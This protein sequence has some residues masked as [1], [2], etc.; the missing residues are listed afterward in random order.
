MLLGLSYILGPLF[1]TWRPEWTKSFVEEFPSDLPE[2]PKL[3]KNAFSRWILT[4]VTLSVIA[5]AA[6][7]VELIP[8]PA[9]LSI[10]SL[11]AGWVRFENST[12]HLTTY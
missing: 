8:N 7:V 2:L 4:L 6:L 9:S 5:S 12:L 10:I 1:A 3:K 11:L